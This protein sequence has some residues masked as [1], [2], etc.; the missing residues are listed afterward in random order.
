MR[1]EIILKENGL[2]E[3]LIILEIFTTREANLLRR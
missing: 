1:M 3:S 2:W